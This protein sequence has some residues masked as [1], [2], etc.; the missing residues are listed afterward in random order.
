MKNTIEFLGNTFNLDMFDEK[1][2]NSNRLP[3]VIL[4]RQVLWGDERKVGTDVFMEAMFP[5]GIGKI[6]RSEALYYC[7]KMAQDDHY[8]KWTA[9]DL[10][11]YGD[12]EA[13][14]HVMDVIEFF[15]DGS[16]KNDTDRRRAEVQAQRNLGE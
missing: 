1:V 6:S 10:M 4:F 9:V 5:A 8:N 15:P 7:S 13:E 3:R 12:T 16:R 14:P 11:W 2:G